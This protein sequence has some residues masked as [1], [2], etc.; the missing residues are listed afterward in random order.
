M[1][2]LIKFVSWMLIL[3]PAFLVLNEGNVWVNVIGFVYL[4]ILAIIC[5]GD[6]KRLQSWIDAVER[7]EKKL[8]NES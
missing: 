6:G 2:D 8:L 7:Y 1:R 5:L 3:L 4:F